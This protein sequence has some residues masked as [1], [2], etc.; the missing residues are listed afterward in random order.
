[1]SC[2]CNLATR[3]LEAGRGNSL[4]RSAASGRYFNCGTGSQ[5]LKWLFIGL[6]RQ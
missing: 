2:A 4:L 5:L 3:N 1:M 6:L